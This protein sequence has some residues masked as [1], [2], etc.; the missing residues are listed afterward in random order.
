MIR[1]LGVRIILGVSLSFLSWNQL[2][3]VAY[4]IDY[5]KPIPAGAS[6][7]DVMNLW[8]EPVEKVEEGI[9][10][11]TIWYYRDGARV[12][13]KEG[14]A[15][16]FR[17]SRSVLAAQ[18]ERV[19]S[20]DGLVIDGLGG[21]ELRGGGGRGAKGDVNSEAMNIIKDIAK[22]VP[23]QPDSPYV[24]PTVQQAAPGAPQQQGFGQG[25]GNQGGFGAPPGMNVA[26][27]DDVGVED[28]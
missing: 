22:D 12:T 14:R 11:Q 19:K 10:R 5:A 17:Y 26:P 28:E 7:A 18:R 24:E 16:S 25:A 27:G 4:A 15:R 23:S 8:G 2:V 20:A 3:G 13:F 9:L 6:F 1:A 21:D